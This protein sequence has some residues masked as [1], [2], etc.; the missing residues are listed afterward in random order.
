MADRGKGIQPASPGRPVDALPGARAEDHVPFDERLMRWVRR[1]TVVGLAASI[2]VHLVLWFIAAHTRIGA[3][4]EGS[5]APMP[6]AVEFAVMTQSELAELERA[7]LDAELPSVPELERETLPEI[8]SLELPTEAEITGS[9]ADLTPNDLGV[10]AGD[11]SQS[12]G[13]GEGGAGSGSA[14][15]F[16]VEATG[17]RFIY[18]VDVSGS[19]AVGGKMEALQRELVT[20]VEGLLEAADFQI[21]T[22]NDSA[23]P[24]ESRRSW[25]D[26]D[27]RG[28]RTARRAIAK[29]TSGGGTNPSPAFAIAFDM[30][31]PPEAIYFMTDGEFHEGVASEIATLNAEYKVPVHCIAFVSRGA[32]PLMRRIASQSGGTYTFV[33]SPV[34]RR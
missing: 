31:P 19:M 14:R 12:A 18:I 23:S 11:V 9:L 4:G 13:V 34:G 7:T 26:A 5:P 10:G 33:P 2:L 20:S 3:P 30:R 1:A 6:G 28:K 16:G 27:A 22:F 32:E 29:F 24:I 8:E 25:I 15:F 17:S 21:I